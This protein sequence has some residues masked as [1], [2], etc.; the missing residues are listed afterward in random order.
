MGQGKSASVFGK[1]KGYHRSGKL[2]GDSIKM[3]FFPVLF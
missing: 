3:C 2:S 1:E